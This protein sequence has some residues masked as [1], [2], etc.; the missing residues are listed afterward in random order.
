[1]VEHAAVNRG[2]VGSSPTSGAIFPKENG[3]SGFS[4]QILHTKTPDSRADDRPMKFPLTIK[5]RGLE[6][7]VYRATIKGKKYYRASYRAGGKRVTKTCH[8]LKDARAAA[9]DGLKNVHRGQDGMA[10]LTKGE[11]GK[12]QVALQL[13]NG[14]GFHDPVKVATEFLTAKDE[15]EGGSLV[16]AAK[17]YRRRR[18]KVKRVTFSHA[19]DKWLGYQQSRVAPLT[20]RV[21]SGVALKLKQAFQ[22]DCCDLGRE[23]LE[24]L[25]DS[26]K[27]KSP[28]WRNHH[29]YVLRGIV[30]HAIQ[31]QWLT[32]EHRLDDLLADEKAVSKPPE[33][34]TPKEFAVMLDSADKDVLPII[35]LGGFTGARAA[36]ILRM[37]WRD[38]WRIEGY[39]ELEKGK[40]K[41]ARRRLVPICP[42]LEAWLKPYRQMTGSI[43]KGSQAQWDH[44]LDDLHKATGIKGHNLLRHSYAS[45][46]LADVQDAGKVS[47]EMGNS[48]NVLLRDYRELVTPAQGKQ[49][50]SVMP[51]AATGKKIVQ[52]S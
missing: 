24:L 22:V 34:L 6:A 46:R 12:V 41:T 10:S 21:A 28:T 52:M 40:T 3:Q 31:N 18:R 45:Y 16:D 1:M 5:H 19:A 2:V 30:K 20:H 39:V 32:K 8:K 13:L 14:A 38:V 44:A 23:E 49:W 15:L 43:W 17:E 51:K 47:L 9:L 26:L 48:P 36:E 37:N 42:A 33:I 50:F 25:F 11:T 7:K 35:A 27:A 29:R 4:A